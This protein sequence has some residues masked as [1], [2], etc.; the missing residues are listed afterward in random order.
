MIVSAVAR[1]TRSRKR[2]VATAVGRYESS[3]GGNIAG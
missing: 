2:V 1:S 3:S